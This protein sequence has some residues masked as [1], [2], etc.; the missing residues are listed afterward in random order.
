MVD[1]PF[2]Q[3]TKAFWQ[4]LRGKPALLQAS[5]ASKQDMARAAAGVGSC[6]KPSFAAAAGTSRGAVGP[7]GGT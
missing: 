7:S 2:P 5:Y 3:A 6:I 1:D 4:V